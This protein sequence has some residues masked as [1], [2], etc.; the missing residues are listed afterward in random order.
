MSKMIK[1]SKEQWAAIGVE[2]G[3]MKEADI[4]V[5]VVHSLHLR[6]QEIVAKL[7]SMGS[8]DLRHPELESAAQQLHGDL[9]R[10]ESLLRPRS[11]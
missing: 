4:G 11:S 7:D 10:F 9:S 3:F 6:L 5:P 1:L 2:M 8:E